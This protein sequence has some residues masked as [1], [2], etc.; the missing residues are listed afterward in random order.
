MLSDVCKKCGSPIVR[1]ALSLKILPLV[2]IEPDEGSSMQEMIEKVSS[3]K[4]ADNKG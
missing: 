4:I 3:V 2:S 1:S